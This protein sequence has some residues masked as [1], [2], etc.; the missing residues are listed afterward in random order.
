M[1]IY[2]EIVKP[3]TLCVVTM[4]LASCGRF[5]LIYERT[6]DHIERN[7][8]ILYFKQQNLRIPERWKR[9]TDTKQL[10]S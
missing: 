3:S 2:T 9:S 4:F 8:M 5:C 6:E 1:D 7:V 10:K